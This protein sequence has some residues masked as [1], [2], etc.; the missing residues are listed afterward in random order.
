MGDVKSSKVFAITGAGGY[1]GRATVRAASDA[2]HT[3]RAIVRNV[4]SA[5][6]DW[7]KNKNIEIIKADL[8]DA[9][10]NLSGVLAGVDAIIHAAGSFSGRPEDQARDT[11]EASDRLAKAAV[12]AQVARFVLVSSIAVY[13]YGV[14]EEGDVLDEMSPMVSDPGTRDIYCESKLAQEKIVENIII[15]AGSQLATLRVGAVFGPDRLMNGHLGPSVGPFLFLLESAGEIP[16]C[17]VQLCA[18][19]LVKTACNDWSGSDSHLV[20][21]VLDDDRPD[22]LRFAM[23]MKQSGWPKFIV[24]F[25]WH[26]L[27][28]LTQIIPDRLA[29]VGLL[30]RAI[31]ATRLK[32]VKFS[33]KRLHNR[34][35]DVT[36]VTFEDAMKQAISK[37]GQEGA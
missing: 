32:P 13:D 36:M 25:Q 22:R 17:R 1:I 18:D 15:Q 7:E 2:G 14:L 35:D 26:M 6:S 24:P 23:A 29:P 3:V 11:L 37:S 34:L 8:S 31:F 9:S 28:A 21:N 12:A 30:R 10:Q 33:N 16:L 27:N 20:M 5:P 19:V 4:A